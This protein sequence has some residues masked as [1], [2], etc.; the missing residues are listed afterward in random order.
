MPGL[1][2]NGGLM[3]KPPAKLSKVTTVPSGGKIRCPANDAPT[4]VS[5]NDDND[6]FGFFTND[7]PSIYSGGI[8]V[9]RRIR[10]DS[11]LR[12]ENGA[13]AVIDGD[14]NHDGSNIGF[15]GTVP[16]AQ[17]SAYTPSNVSTDRAYDAN[18][19]TTAE[20]ADVL[21][22]LIADLQSLGLLG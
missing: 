1:M 8:G 5:V 4:L 12:M 9:T 7:Q 6:G 20:L 18:S 17:P 16:A 14:V 13:S 19:T 15:Y 22:T 21:G 11:S 10:V 2:N 3:A